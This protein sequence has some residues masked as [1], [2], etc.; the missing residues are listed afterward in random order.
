[1]ESRTPEWRALWLIGFAGFM[2]LYTFNPA[3][4]EYR[5]T[6]LRKR[7]G[8][9]KPGTSGRVDINLPELGQQRPD[10]SR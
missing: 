7:R 1:M 4:G 6:Q 5:A 3:R 10:D 8:S 2:T 9:P